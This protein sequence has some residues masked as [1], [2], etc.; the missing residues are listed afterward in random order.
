MSENEKNYYFWN[1]KEFEGSVREVVC[2]RCPYL[3][4]NGCKNPDPHGCALFRH[5]PDLVRV[6]QRLDNQNIREYAEAVERE[7]PLDCERAPSPGNEC[8]LLDSP[9]CGLDRL[10]P[11][12][13]KAVVKADK[14]LESRA[15]FRA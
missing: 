13:L 12:V 15:G 10:L 14:S 6:A 11:H 2:P 1:K 7:I 5:L 8:R 9:R 4:L 3:G